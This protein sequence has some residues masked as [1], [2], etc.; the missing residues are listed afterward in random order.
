M[1]SIDTILQ[2]RYRVIGLLGQG[3]MGAVYRAWDLRL[4]IPVAVK[5]RVPRP[6]IDSRTLAQLR[7]QFQQEA[8]VLARFSHPHLVRVTD[9]FEELGNAYLV[10]DFVETE[11]H[12]LCRG[13]HPRGV[14]APSPEEVRDVD[15]EKHP[16]R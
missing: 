6:G 9:F 12:L 4:G 7:Q 10:M 14:T 2:N 5:E 3:G 13:R 11:N 1:V 16:D 8:T 15:I